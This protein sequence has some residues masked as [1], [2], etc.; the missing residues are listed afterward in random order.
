[1]SQLTNTISLTIYHQN[2]HTKIH[3]KGKHIFAW[4]GSQRKP[5]QS[6][7]QSSHSNTNIPQ[8]LKYRKR[9]AICTWQGFY[10]NGNFSRNIKDFIKKQYLNYFFKNF[11][12]KL[13]LKLL[14]TVLRIMSVLWLA[15]CYAV[16]NFFITGGKKHS[17][18]S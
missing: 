15:T 12:K 16:S 6:H 14:K 2:I 10:W 13:A 3:M 9:L 18:I 4:G 17:D 1:M 11:I 7:L 5:L 8:T